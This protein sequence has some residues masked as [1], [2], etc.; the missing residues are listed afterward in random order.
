MF[1]DYPCHLSLTL[2]G[3]L[4]LTSSPADFLVG[5]VG[6]VGDLSAELANGLAAAARLIFRD[7]FGILAE[8]RTTFALL[9]VPLAFLFD[10]GTLLFALEILVLMEEFVELATEDIVLA[11][12]DS[13]FAFEVPVDVRCLLSTDRW[14]RGKAII[15]RN[16]KCAQ[17]KRRQRAS[18]N[19]PN[20]VEKSNNQHTLTGAPDHVKV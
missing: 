8:L 7:G 6:L 20:L 12:D 11:L 2:I 17:S 18:L 4:S 15:V 14:E 19:F 13:S 16:S 1:I 5:D 9:K 3:S 10:G